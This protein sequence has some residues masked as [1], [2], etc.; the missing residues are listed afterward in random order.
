MVVVK[1]NPLFLIVF[2][3]V[4][5]IAAVCSAAAP[6]EVS[7]DGK[8]NINTV[9]HLTPSELPPKNPSPGDLYFTTNHQLMLF[10]KKWIA[11]LTS[12][13]LGQETFTKGFTS[14]GT[15]VVPATIK[16]ITV[17]LVAGGRTG[18][19][20]TNA[21]YGG[22]G[23]SSGEIVVQEL[24]VSPGESINVTVGS[25]NQNSYFGTTLI[26]R[27]TQG[28]DGNAGGSPYNCTS[29]KGAAFCYPGNGGAGARGYGT[30]S[31]AAS[32]KS[33]NLIYPAAGGTGGKGY[34][35]GGGG[36]AGG[37]GAGGGGA[38]GYCLISYKMN[39]YQHPDGEI[40]YEQP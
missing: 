21:G 35:A 20:G 17:T 38:P 37:A 22:T 10:T 32:G 18:A 7:N 12:T 40:Y 3:F 11:I 24:T 26:A 1:K 8:V 16:T 15:W 13:Y 23:G 28:A 19:S 34:G 33:T 14:S 27:Y 29:I 30:A 6:L 39:K 36:G 9:L 2:L 4:F 5:S 25:Q 31:L